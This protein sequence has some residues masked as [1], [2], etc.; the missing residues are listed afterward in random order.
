M[1]SHLLITLIFNPEKQVVRHRFPLSP[2]T[3]YLQQLF[4]EIFFCQS[5]KV[6]KLQASDVQKHH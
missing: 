3:V 1:N 2:T 6:I 5:A 4:N